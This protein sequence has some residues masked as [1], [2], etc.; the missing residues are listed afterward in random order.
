MMRKNKN[1][2]L[3]YTQPVLYTVDGIG[4]NPERVRNRDDF[5]FGPP[6]GPGAPPETRNPLFL[7]MRKAAKVLH[8]EHK[9]HNNMIFPY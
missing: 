3:K 6:R 8:H 5:T 9:V 1:K 2:L 4:P 7:V